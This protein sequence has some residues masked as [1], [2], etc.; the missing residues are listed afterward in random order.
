MYMIMFVL[1]DPT[2]L[3]ALLERWYEIGIGGV[4]IAES[5]GFHRR[6]V[7]RAKL[8]LTFLMEPV[9]VGGEEGNYTLYAMVPDQ[10]MVEKC[11][12]VTEQVVGDL[13]GPNTGVF[14]AW[15]LSTVKGVPEHDTGSEAGA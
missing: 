1:D 6:R 9:S 8:H 10:A 14:S 5:T 2:K 4:T 13:D 11:L 3:D 12:S 7:Q 15:P